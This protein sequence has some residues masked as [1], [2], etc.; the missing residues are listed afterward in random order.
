MA[1]LINGM[2][3]MAYGP[4]SKY[5]IRGLVLAAAVWG[6]RAAGPALNRRNLTGELQPSSAFAEEVPA[7][8]T[9]DACASDVLIHLIPLA[10]FGRAGRL[11]FALLLVCFSSAMAVGSPSAAS[12]SIDSSAFDLPAAAWNDGVP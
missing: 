10:R 5:I 11:R 12:C 9:S 7:H 3:L 1:V 6:R 8:L 2:T 4:E